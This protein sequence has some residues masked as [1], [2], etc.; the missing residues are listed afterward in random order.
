MENWYSVINSAEQNF[1]INNN[2]NNNNKIKNNNE[3]IKFPI[4]T[5]WTMHFNQVLGPKSQ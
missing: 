1:V 5:L 4:R 3:I 2:N